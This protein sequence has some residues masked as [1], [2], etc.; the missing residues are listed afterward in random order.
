MLTPFDNLSNQMSCKLASLRHNIDEHHQQERIQM[1]ANY[2]HQIYDMNNVFDKK[3]VMKSLN[4]YLSPDE[5]I[6]QKFHQLLN[7]AAP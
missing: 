6:Y 7:L 3:R 4:R 5:T 2:I 1:Y